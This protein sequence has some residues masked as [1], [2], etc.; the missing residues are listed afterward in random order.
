MLYVISVNPDGKAGSLQLV[1]V[2]MYVSHVYYAPSS[3]SHGRGLQQK[4]KLRNKVLC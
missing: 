3:W 4:V 2:C 1:C